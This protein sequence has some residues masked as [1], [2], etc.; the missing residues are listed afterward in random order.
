MAFKELNYILGQTKWNGSFCIN[1]RFHD[2]TELAY[3]NFDA[4]QQGFW[5]GS[6]AISL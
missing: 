5:N 4:F 3:L 1:K 6:H 2:K